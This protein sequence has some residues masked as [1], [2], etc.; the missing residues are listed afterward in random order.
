M[1]TLPCSLS[2]EQPMP[3][4]ASPLPTAVVCVWGVLSVFVACTAICA[5][6]VAVMCA[7]SLLAKAESDGFG[8]VR[9]WGMGLE[10]TVLPLDVRPPASN[11]VNSALIPTPMSANTLV[12]APPTGKLSSRA[13]IPPRHHCSM[14][15]LQA[16]RLAGLL[17]PY[18]SPLPGNC[19][20]LAHRRGRRLGAARNPRDVSQGAGLP[21]CAWCAQ[22][23]ILPVCVFA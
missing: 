9:K 13:Q 16:D 14:S 11:D 8:R 20:Q 6:F 19:Q 12:M 4:A 23:T 22:S 15:L 1:L 7:C 21:A 18:H 17:L 2:A 10:A 3:P 5:M